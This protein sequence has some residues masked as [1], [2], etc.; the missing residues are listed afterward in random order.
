MAE[1]YTR[2]RDTGAFILIDEATRDTVAAGMVLRAHEDPGPPTGPHSPGHRSGTS[3]RCRGASAGAC[4]A[5]AAPPSGS[6]ASRPRAS[7]R[8][9]RSSSA[10]SSGSAALRTCSTARTSA[11]GSAATSAS[12][13]P[14][15]PSTPAASPASRACSP[16]PASSPIT[17][18]VSPAAADR[19]FA[20]ELHEEAG[21]DFVEA[22]VDTPLEE[23]ERRDPHGLYA[24]ARAGE[25]P[26]FTGIDAPYEA[27][28]AG[29]RAVARRRRSGRRVRAA[30]DRATRAPIAA[31][32]RRA[33]RSPSGALRAEPG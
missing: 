17:A 9:P 30:P 27:A 12:P 7:R 21:L 28:R 10:R 18:L 6:P 16:M 26:G 31:T 8:S 20:R 15:A 5:C 22:W 3:R 23:C 1:P 13:P 2:N 32:R 25:I 19:E 4:S 14:T 33:P 24:R 29:G 11:T